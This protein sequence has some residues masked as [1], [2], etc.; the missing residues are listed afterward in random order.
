MNSWCGRT[1]GWLAL[2]KVPLQ[3]MRSPSILTQCD[4]PLSQWTNRWQRSHNV[5]RLSSMSLPE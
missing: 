3:R 2:A 4:K 1:F 5:I